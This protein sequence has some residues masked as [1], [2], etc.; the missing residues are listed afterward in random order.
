M[1]QR[2]RASGLITTDSR[3]Y[4]FVASS[5]VKTAFVVCLGRQR[6]SGEYEPST[7]RHTVVEVGSGA[8]TGLPTMV[9]ADFG[10]KVVTVPTGSR[11]TAKRCGSV[12]RP[13]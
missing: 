8:L 4:A 3:L 7:E 1:L 10:A 5:D 2:R 12:V 11:Q 6:G 9:M 13:A